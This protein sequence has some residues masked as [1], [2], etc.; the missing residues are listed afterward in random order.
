MKIS[1]KYLH[2]NICI[3]IN[4]SIVV[5]GSVTVCIVK[6]ELHNVITVQEC[7]A[8]K[9]SLKHQCWYIKKFRTVLVRNVMMYMR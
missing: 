8:R 4:A 9:A 6:Q 7:D 3:G 2:D 1:K 5:A